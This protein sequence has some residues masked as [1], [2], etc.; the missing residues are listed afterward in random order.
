[1]PLFP[2][3][4]GLFGLI[5]GSFLNVCIYRLPRGE[6]VVFP[7]SHCTGCGA[8]IRAYD[9]VPLLSFL[10]LGGRCRFCKSPISLQY[11]VV[12]LLSGL[13]FYYCAQIWGVE[14]PTFV[15]SLFIAAVIVLVFVDYQHQ[16]LPNKI[17]LPGIPA[18]IVLSLFQVPELFR[19]PLS[20]S[21]ASNVSSEPSD[22]LLRIS[23][24]V[25]GSFLAGGPLW[26]IAFLYPI[27]RKKQGLGMGDVKMMAMV[28]AFLGWRLALLTILIGSVLGLA[29]GI[30][31]IAFRG[32]S[33]QSKLPFGTFLGSGAVVALF[34][35][36]RFFQ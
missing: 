11:P 8:L 22:A 25:V 3:F 5:V 30:F 18:G 34:F 10:L 36:I 4:Y 1:M 27:V 15:N 23:G 2:I 17:T 14:G 19:D 31:M 9:N 33:L 29:V 12:E 35:G 26:L 20:Y 6:S 24:S 16:I 7:R 21:L 32:G 13:S 28:G